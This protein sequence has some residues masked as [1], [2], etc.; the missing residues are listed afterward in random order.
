MIIAP[1]QVEFWQHLHYYNILI[2]TL[3]LLLAGGWIFVLRA[4]LPHLKDEWINWRQGIFARE[5]PYVLMQVSLPADNN[6]GIEAIEQA[7]SQ[8]MGL[9]RHFTWWE[10]W[11]KG[12]Y[13]LKIVLEMVSFEGLIKFYVSSTYKHKHLVEHAFYSQYPGAEI[14]VLKPEEDFKHL[15]PDKM[16]DP[17]FEML[18]TEYVLE[19]PSY[20]PL[21]TYK[22]YQTPD[23]KFNDPLRH[24]WE[25]MHNL[26]EGEYIWYQI[27]I[28][29]EYESWAI[30]QRHHIDRLLGKPVDK[31]RPVKSLSAILTGELW[32]ILKYLLMLPFT[33]LRE[34]FRQLFSGTGKIVSSQVNDHTY[35]EVARQLKGTGREA[36]R[37]IYC[38]HEAFLSQFRKKPAAKAGSGASGAC[39]APG[40]ININNQISVDPRINVQVPG[41]TFPN[42]YLFLSDKQKRVIDAIERKLSQQIFK[43][44]IRMLYFAK[45]PV[46]SKF[47][48]WSEIHGSFKHF[49][50]L[51]FNSLGRGTYTKTST[52]YFLAK[53][54][55]RMRQNSIINNT[56]A[57][58]WLAGD[59]W[60]HC[61]AE[62]LA[63]LWHFP[64]K[65][66][67][68]ANFEV[69]KEPVRPA[70][71]E[72][73][74][75]PGYNK[76][77]LVENVFG[78]VPENLPVTEYVP[79][80]YK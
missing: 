24:M 39:A 65:Q 67:M 38:L 61:S 29:P 16:P 48:F 13:V 30:G 72:L 23:G 22:E 31:K 58:D 42:D 20:Y 36:G 18:G 80:T 34:I 6:R 17:E 79:Y 73:R 54:R 59:T 7:Y 68:L 15:F 55:K 56:K 41:I 69:V 66:D 8:L 37:Q 4:L 45:K 64:A 14:K 52:D 46:Y 26:K 25:L 47:R 49:N 9:R 3:E 70:E 33:L 76:E 50:D 40:P 62:E 57:R 53:V 35:G 44:C 75:R 51:D 10:K 32:S 5:N 27:V 77:R 21:K 60:I 43:T 1:W 11:W 74:V 28:V 12:Q 63:T 78:E 19:K 2:L 71:G